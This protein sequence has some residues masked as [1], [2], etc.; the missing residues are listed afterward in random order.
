MFAYFFISRRLFT[1]NF[2]GYGITTY[3]NQKSF[4]V[5]IF[6]MIWVNKNNSSTDFL[7][8]IVNFC[9][10][11]NLDEKYWFDYGLC[12]MNLLLMIFILWLYIFRFNIS[13]IIMVKYQYLV[14]INL[15]KAFWKIKIQLLVINC[16]ICTIIKP[17]MA[18]SWLV[19]KVQVYKSSS[20]RT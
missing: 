17:I 2:Y 12:Y 19:K 5:L 14:N 6:I 20:T 10:R 15:A 16:N 11:N 7:S 18:E 8:R 3:T 1:V 9:G 4:A 13:A